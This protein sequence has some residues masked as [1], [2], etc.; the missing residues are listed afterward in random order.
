MD[1][2]LVELYIERGRLRERIGAQRLQLARDLAPLRTVSDMADRGTRLVR[3]TQQWMA[4]H[5]TVVTALVVALV[6]W[7]PRAVWR[8]LRWGYSLWR[9]WSGLR[10]WVMGRY[11]AK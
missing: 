11:G 6:A 8:S 10:T 3:Q 9:R 1:A 7:R 4:G 2:R 5:P